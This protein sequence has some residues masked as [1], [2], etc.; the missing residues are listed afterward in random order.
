[1][2]WESYKL[3]H[4]PITDS[5][6]IATA[7]LQRKRGAPSDS[8]DYDDDG[9]D[10]DEYD[11]DE[12]DDDDDES[13]YKSHIKS[14]IIAER[15]IQTAPIFTH[16]SNAESSLRQYERCTICLCPT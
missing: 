16:H 3:R 13:P 5:S 6:F 4:L 8:P 11:D 12:Y 7:L 1:M 15:I 14:H 2:Q 9:Y 10:D